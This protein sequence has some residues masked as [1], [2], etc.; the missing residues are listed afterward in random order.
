MFWLTNTT[1]KRKLMLITM[2][3]TTVA[4]V[5]AI[6]GFLTWE[7]FH[8]KAY[9]LSE[10]NSH[11]AMI[12]TNVQAA[13]AFQD[14]QDAEQILAGLKID[15][16][17]AFACVYDKQNQLFAQYL[18]EDVTK[19]FRPPEILKNTHI[20]HDGFLSVFRDISV[21]GEK[22]GSVCLTTELTVLREAL[23]WNSIIGLIIAVVVFIV[24]YF[25]SSRLLGI[26]SGPI[27]TLAE[28][29]AKFG[30]GQLDHRVEL[31]SKDELGLLAGSFNDMASKLKDSYTGL[32][33]KV[34]ERTT[35]LTSANTKLEKEVVERAKAEN[36]LKRHIGHLNCFYTLSRLIEQSGISLEQIF[37][38]TINLIRSAHQHPDNTCVRI[39][40]DGI[41]YQ[42]DNFQKT[43]LSEYAEIRVYGH[44]KGNIEVY[45]I[46]ENVQSGASVFI[47]EEHDLIKAVAEHLGRIAGR[48][49][50]HDE[51]QLF[52]DL[53]NHSN[54]CIFVIE[55]EWGRLLDVND[56]ACQSLGY[57]RKELLTM[58]LR[59]I[60]QSLTND[61]SW[62]QKADELS[63]KADVVIEGQHKRKDSTTFAA[64]T[65]LKLVAQDKG[66]YIIAV[67][68]D[69]TER[70]Q[71]QERLRQAAEEWSTTFNS[72]TDLVSVHDLQC[73]LVRVN[74]AFAETFGIEPDRITDK[75]CY[76]VIHGLD[77]QYF[78]CPLKEALR[79]KQPITSEF[80]EP[81]LEIYVEVSVSPI[82]DEKGEV[83]GFLH[84]AKD[85]TERKQ[86]EEKQKQLF[87]EVKSANQELNDFAHIVSHDLKAPLYGI[88]TIADWI[89]S[90]YQDKL[91]DDGKE[92][93]GLLMGRVDRM[94]NL[95]DG[96]LTYSRIGRTKEQREPVDLNELVHDIIDTL[97]VPENITVE[98]DDELPVISCDQTRILQVF[99]NLLSNAVKYMDKPQGKI[100]ISC[101]EESD[102][103]KFSVADN[104][105]GIE[106]KDFE[107]IF[108]IFQ[109]GAPRDEID[110][111]GVG[112]SVV[113]KIVE[114]YEG[115]IWV[116]S[117]VDKGSTFI[118]TYPKNETELNSLEV[119]ENTFAKT[120]V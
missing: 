27:Q 68:R 69:I 100:T 89:S 55:P 54:D 57:T 60:E 67:S 90:D 10:T 26:V 79:T 15:Q 91:D 25:Q 53:L 109:T 5:M 35:E 93:L 73:R 88:R 120:N 30:D 48:K 78:K 108:Q 94:Y 80:Y 43:E 97:A 31:K 82:L 98:V 7:Y 74:K 70:K 19:K 71:A 102:L 41:N 111:T 87:E 52:R 13:L 39:T 49:Q 85:I 107:R 115:T 77:R 46:G 29:A 101:V 61:I 34:N 84:I 58:T 113:K 64:E 8:E 1:I 110:S 104:G 92:Q 14:K 16:C 117:Q 38:E 76:E 20:F 36:N 105:P 22:F 81:K 50:T 106:E 116:E 75:K 51:L 18:R 112:L 4:L 119:E 118:F 63:F 32:E 62:K 114:M 12:A 33:Q 24:A 37:Q 99:Q 17:I 6:V 66:E 86:A 45:Y 83:T 28:S 11:A 47:K 65:S 59:D 44:K 42:T 3:T 72:I 95:I 40:Y 103:W 9:V 21:D 2:A 96:I 56:K 23:V